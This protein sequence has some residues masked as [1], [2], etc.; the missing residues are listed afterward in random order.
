MNTTTA[1]LDQEEQAQIDA[2]RARKA[3]EREHQLKLGQLN[4]SVTAAETA[5]VEFESKKQFLRQRKI[6]LQDQLT[7][8]WPLQPSDLSLQ[9]NTSPLQCI[10]ESHGTMAAI[11]AALADAPRIKKHLD[12]QLHKAKQQL[13]DFQQ[14]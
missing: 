7:R 11:D 4:K 6:D 13:A 3:R 9:V 2:I 10:V 12:Q 14:K 5:L 8:L 1:T